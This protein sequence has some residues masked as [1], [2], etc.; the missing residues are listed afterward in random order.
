M[1]ER[2]STNII[3]ASAL[4]FAGLLASAP[5]SAG[6]LYPVA[7]DY[8]ID[9]CVAEIGKQANYE[10]GVRVEHQ[11][12]SEERR[13]IGYTLRIDTTIYSDNEGEVVREYATKCVVAGGEQPIRFRIKESN[14]GA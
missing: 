12:L 3:A 8:M 13:S 9:Q 11:V 10:G 4:A 1:N 14:T 7:P 6:G 5:A 2:N